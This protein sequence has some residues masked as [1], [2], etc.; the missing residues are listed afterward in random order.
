M[1][2]NDYLVTHIL[3]CIFF[4]IQQKKKKIQVW[5]NKRVTDDKIF[6]F[7]WTIPLIWY[8]CPV[9]EM[10]FCA[11]FRYVCTEKHLLMQGCRTQ[12][13]EDRNPAKFSPNTDPTRKPCSVL[14][15]KDLIRWISC[16]WFRVGAKF[17]RT[18]AFQE[19]YTPLLVSAWVLNWVLFHIYLC[20]NDL[21]I[22]YVFKMAG[23]T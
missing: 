12:F 6:I 9:W 1:A 10:A 3:H 18:V 15:L 14:S 23:N 22:G 17:S 20:L 19:F 13:L 2:T 4:C 8:L 21:I 7:G 5:N 11:G 16:V